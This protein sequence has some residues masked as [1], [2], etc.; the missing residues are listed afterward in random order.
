M[1][2]HTT[3]RLAYSAGLSIL[4]VAEDGTKRP[5]VAAWGEYQTQRPTPADMRAF[6]FAARAGLGMIAGA[7]SRCRECW[8]FDTN[9]VFVAFCEAADQS[10]L[11][12]V[13]ARIRAGYEDQTPG[14]GRRWIAEYPDG[15]KWR[16]C[17]LACRPGRAGEPKIKTLIELPT[18]SILAPSNGATHPSGR[19]Y[20]HVSGAF[21][22]IASYTVEERDALI[23]LARTFDVMPRRPYAPPKTTRTTATSD[24]PGDDFNRRTTWSDLLEPARWTRVYERGDVTYWRRPDKTIGV[25][26]TTNYAGSDLLYMFSS[27]T[28]FAPD[29]SYTKFGAYAVLEHG[30]DFSK[31]AAALARRGF[32]DDEA[33]KPATSGAVVVVLSEVAPVAVDWMWPGRVARGKY[34]LWAGDPGVG[35]STLLID[36]SARLSRGTAWPDGGDAPDGPVLL[37]SA[38][39]GLADTIRPRL[40]LAGGDPRH[41]HVLTAI[42]DEKGERPFNLERDVSQLVDAIARVRPVLV[43]VDPITAYLGNTDAHRD[44]EVRGLLAPLVAELERSHIALVAV[45]HLSKDAQR[46][47]LHRPGGSIGFVAAARVVLA[48]AADPHAPE[49]RVIASLKNNL[50]KPAA[51]LSF[52]FAP[53]GRLIFDAA[54]VDVSADALLRP[55]VDAD[56]QTDA[57]DVIRDLLDDA[58]DWP[59]DAKRAL[60]AGRAHGIADRT[61]QWT[62]KRLGIRIARV[63]FGPGGRWVW[64]RPIDAAVAPKNPDVAPMAPMQEPADIDA[65]QNIDATKSSFPRAREDFSASAANDDGPA[66][67]TEPAAPD[68]SDPIGAHDEEPVSE[69]PGRAEVAER[70]DRRKAAGERFDRRR[71][72]R[73]RAPGKSPADAGEKPV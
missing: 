22:T 54:P 25:S 1:N 66:W 50:G 29:T 12:D 71:P 38:E 27:S 3:A 8:D 32:G 43:G 24:R 67:V 69:P 56:H 35:K 70:V 30:G 2:M 55:L 4:P 44:G 63:G 65:K 36:V 11:G 42:R 15:I 18:F 47:A 40:D 41:V 53:N 52:T 21:N 64:Q 14:G 46:A 68:A 28:L 45:G 16:D 17:T 57:E 19:A 73:R 34:T 20:V 49:R 13:V 58:A 33:A 9:H 59:L 48:V 23:E 10:G 5:D 61:L 7:A 51:S 62:A 39:D 60:E 37:L 26:A 6:T 72:R 31:A